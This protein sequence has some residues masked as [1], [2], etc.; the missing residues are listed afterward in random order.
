MQA[1]MPEKTTRDIEPA[2][3]PACPGCGAVYESAEESCAA[4]F[5]ALL[6]L[7][8]SRVEPWGSRH[9]LAF[10]AF[11]LQHPDRFARDVLERAWL[12][13][14]SVYVQGNDAGRVVKALRRAGKRLPDWVLPPLPVG[15]PAPRFAVTIAGLGP[16]PAETYPAQLDAWCTAALAGWREL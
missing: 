5:E 2:R 7:D 3:M 8:H 6:A 16:F 10:S 15:T 11:A 12:I 1:G 4:R 14:F 9:A 13:L